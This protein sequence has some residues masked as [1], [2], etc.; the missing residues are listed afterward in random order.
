MLAGGFPILVRGKRRSPCQS[1]SF[2]LLFGA[3]CRCQFKTRYKTLTSFLSDESTQ[4]CFAVA[5]ESAKA[6]CGDLCVTRV[7]DQRMP[8]AMAISTTT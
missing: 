1:Q 2:G 4:F 6:T 3:T 8:L 7:D 5:M